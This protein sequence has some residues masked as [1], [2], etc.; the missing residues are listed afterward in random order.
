MILGRNLYKVGLF[1]FIM[2]ISPEL[3]EISGIHAGDGYM[4]L[5]GGKGEV[6]ISGSFEEQIYYDNHVVPLFNRVFN[7]ELI[8]RKFSRGSYG[9]VCYRKHV[10]E[11]LINLGFPLGKKSKTLSI[12]KKILDS[13]NA[14]IYTKFLR[15]LFD[16]DGNLYFRKS[17]VGINKFQRNYNHY[18]VIKLVSIS[19]FL[20]EDIIH[21]LFQMDI[22]FYYHSY[23][24]KK[25]N[26]SRKYYITISGIDGLERWMKFVGMKNPVKLSRYLVW[27]KFGFCP[28][29]TSLKQREDILNGRLNIKDMGL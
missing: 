12:P 26:E 5:R 2:K 9:F 17:Y 25:E 4:R 10:R 11:V 13:K 6:D 15:G 16:T 28:P 27:K 3:A 24:S 21:M 18:P 23:D 20:V 1:L 22:V 14:K 8:G 7:L 29:N 19:R